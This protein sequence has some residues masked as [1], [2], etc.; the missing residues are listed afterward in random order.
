MYV[1]GVDTA[2]VNETEYRDGWVRTFRKKDIPCISGD[3]RKFLTSYLNNGNIEEAFIYLQHFR[4]VDD[5][6]AS[7]VIRD[8]LR[9]NL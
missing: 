2:G 9:G 1:N 8:M 4:G 5:E 3:E 7:L 6:I